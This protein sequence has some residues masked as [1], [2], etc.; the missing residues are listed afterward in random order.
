MP[1]PVFQKLIDVD[2]NFT[3]VGEAIAGTSPTSAGWRIKRVADNS[4]DMTIIWGHSTSAFDKTWA[5]RASYNYEITYA[6]ITGNFN[7]G[8]Y[9]AGSYN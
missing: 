8:A 5:N 6:P 9:N 2:G 4:P 3:Y 1:K 7:I